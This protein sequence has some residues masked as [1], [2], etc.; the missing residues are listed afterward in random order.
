MEVV[1]INQV[2][3]LKKLSRIDFDKLFCFSDNES[4]VRSFASAQGFSQDRIF[5]CGYNLNDIQLAILPPEEIRHVFF[6]IEEYGDVRRK[7]FK[8]F[9]L[10]KSV[11][12]INSGIDVDTETNILKECVAFY[13]KIKETAETVAESYQTGSNWK[14]FLL[15][16]RPDFYSAIANAN[17]DCL[18]KLFSNLVRTQVTTG[19]DM[20][21]AFFNIYLT[22]NSYRVFFKILET[23]AVSLNRDVTNQDIE[24][25]GT[26]VGNPY[27]IKIGNS[28]VGINDCLFHIRARSIKKLLQ[29]GVRHGIVM[30]IGSGAGKFGY[31]FQKICNCTYIA[32][33]V[34]ENLIVAAYY[35]K[36][37]CP[38]KKICYATM[39]VLLRK[40]C[41]L[42]I[43]F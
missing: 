40:S 12:N 21:E 34:P 6:N 11:E 16:S 10:S 42:T 26:L 35:L 19:I 25:L 37:S 43:L 18:M 33:D 2:E 23:W 15:K 5:V 29:N 38:N 41:Q 17:F 14:D 22:A 36:M 20:S 39:H 13:K 9:S 8:A 24:E 27:G 28:I 32:L 31:Y 4:E 1:G 7:Q 3:D 30:D